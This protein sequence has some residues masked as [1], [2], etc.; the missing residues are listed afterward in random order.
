[1]TIDHHILTVTRDADDEYGP[2]ADITCPGVTETCAEWVECKRTVCSARAT[3]DDSTDATAHGEQHRY[4]DE[5]TPT[6]YWAVRS[7]DCY[8]QNHGEAAAEEFAEERHLGSGTYPVT[9]EAD[10]STVILVMADS[11]AEAVAS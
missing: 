3:D 9:V 5:D 7:G 6:G 11:P 1:M 2:A 8:A 4:F 10:G